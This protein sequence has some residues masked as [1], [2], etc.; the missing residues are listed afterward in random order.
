[1]DVRAAY[2]LENCF[3]QEEEKH[4]LLITT[5][6]AAPENIAVGNA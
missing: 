1:M 5:M 3:P 6:I 2:R 4:G